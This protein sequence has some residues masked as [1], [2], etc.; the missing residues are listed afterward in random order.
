MFC[1][2]C[3][4]FSS[5]LAP[6]NFQSWLSDVE[7]DSPTF[8]VLADLW[9]LQGVLMTRTL[10]LDGGDV[11]A[12]VS[13]NSPTSSNSSRL[14]HASDG[15]LP[16]KLPFSQD[17]G[18]EDSDDFAQPSPA[19]RSVASISA[20]SS[21]SM[22]SQS[23]SPEA[24]ARLVKTFQ[25]KGWT[26]RGLEKLANAG[27]LRGRVW[28]VVHELFA[29]GW[30]ESDLVPFLDFCKSPLSFDSFLDEGMRRRFEFLPSTV[31]QHARNALNFICLLFSQVEFGKI[32]E[33]IAPSLLV[34]LAGMD[35][36]SRDGGCQDRALFFIDFVRKYQQQLTM[37]SY[38]SIHIAERNF[39]VL[40]YL[41]GCCQNRFGKSSFL[42]Y[43]FPEQTQ[44]FRVDDWLKDCIG[45]E[46]IRF[47]SEKNMV[48]PSAQIAAAVSALNKVF[49]MSEEQLQALGSSQSFAVQIAKA[50][51]KRSFDT[52]RRF[53]ELHAQIPIEVIWTHIRPAY[54]EK[55]GLIQATYAKNSLPEEP[56][57]SSFAGYVIQLFSF[58]LTESEALQVEERVRT[59]SSLFAFMDTWAACTD[60][61]QQA[62]KA[63]PD[64]PILFPNG[65]LDRSSALERARAI[66]KLAGVGHIYAASITERTTEQFLTSYPKQDLLTE[67]YFV[68]TCLDQRC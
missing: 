16:P 24:I 18:D 59:K 11:V 28:D 41:L 62:K 66:D 2:V 50:T 40:N 7:K 64:L 55:A 25:E 22:T 27:P 13:G 65:T 68:Q 20:T 29:Q 42:N 3:I 60:G 38:G 8:P 12:P 43:P 45:A 33:H 32:F 26:E 51:H 49:F 44:K 23:S 53:L 36:S 31:A 17:D 47:L 52:M 67:P 48:G 37:K 39:V 10:M 14:S 1:F 35:N 63:F 9:Q 56:H 5:D 57:A 4:L 61:E 34:D 19:D 15:N 54:S 21:K 30:S 58:N 6:I 46:K